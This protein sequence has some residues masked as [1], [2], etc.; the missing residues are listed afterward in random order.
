[1]VSTFFNIHILSIK[2]DEIIKKEVPLHW[3]A[4][5]KMD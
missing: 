4:L 1:M 5:Q 2:T 3:I